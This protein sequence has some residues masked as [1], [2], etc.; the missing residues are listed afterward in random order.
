ME[1]GLFPG[2]FLVEEIQVC[3]LIRVT[4]A[5]R[6]AYAVLVLQCPQSPSKDGG[7]SKYMKISCFL[8]SL[9]DGF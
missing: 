7:F 3:S 6:H 8:R 2:S 1:R 4:P 5:K 9:L